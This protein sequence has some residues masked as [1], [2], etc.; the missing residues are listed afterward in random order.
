MLRRLY[1][2][3]QLVLFILYVI[4]IN[5]QSEFISVWPGYILIALG[6]LLGIWSLGSLGQSLSPFPTPKRNGK[7]VT[8]G[9][10]RLVRHPIYL[11]VMMVMLG[12][13]LYSGRWSRWIILICIS[14]LFHFKSNYEE[15]LLESKFGEAYH[16][17]KE[18]V[19]KILPKV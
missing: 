19:G 11:A 9:A 10:Y 15:Q 14:I 7:L 13:A 18:E 8:G 17:Y 2:P 1:V 5:C 4:P 3:I 16:R 12:G 6:L